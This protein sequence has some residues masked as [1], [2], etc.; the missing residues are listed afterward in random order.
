MPYEEWKNSKKVTSN[1]E[2]KK[3]TTT[4]MRTNPEFSKFDSK[5]NHLFET[6]NLDDKMLT[7]LVCRYLNVKEG[8]INDSI[9]TGN[10][11]SMIDPQFMD[12]NLGELLK[13]IDQR[14]SRG[15]YFLK[16]ASRKYFLTKIHSTCNLE[17]SPMMLDEK[18]FS[19]FVEMGNN[20]VT[21]RFFEKKKI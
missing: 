9:S 12:M 6:K 2:I 5:S 8:I 17:Q 15:D 3:D 18:I 1:K 11:S 13:E 19:L 14:K 7:D 21:S 10:L 4:T 20:L 16:L